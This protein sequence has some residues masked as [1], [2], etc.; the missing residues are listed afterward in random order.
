MSKIV[1]RLFLAVPVTL[2]AYKDL[3]NDFENV[4]QGRWV[5]EKN[6]H[7]TLQFFADRYEKDFLIELIATLDLRAKSSELKGL[8][9]LPR[10]NILYGQTQNTIFYTL[11]SQL[12]E[13]LILPR[14]GE[15]L[16]HVTLMRIKKVLNQ[17]LLEEKLQSYETNSI[18]VL[19]DKIQLLQSIA[20]ASGAEYTLIKEF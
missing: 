7:L 8:S 6:L 1:K 13:A 11:H 10:S 14:E 9:L 15:F 12:R 4:L 2:F 16:P 19:H 5:P 3:Q 17:G 18:G 20:T